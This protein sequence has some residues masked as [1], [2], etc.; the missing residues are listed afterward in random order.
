MLHDIDGGPILRKLR[1]PA[2]A[3]DKDN[4]LAFYALFIPV[5]HEDQMR[6]ELNLSHL[7]PDLQERI[8][9]IIRK[10]WSVFNEKL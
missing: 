6:K 5:K 9:A 8:Y 3:M 4:D 1:H 7:D 10:Y 2:S